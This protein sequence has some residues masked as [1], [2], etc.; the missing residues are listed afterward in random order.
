MKL[1]I[2]KNQYEILIEFFNLHDIKVNI[3]KVIMDEMLVTLG[4]AK[5]V[6]CIVELDITE[7]EIDRIWEICNDYDIAACNSEDSL[8]MEWDPVLHECVYKPTEAERL[9]NRYGLIYT[10]FME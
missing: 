1:E 7:E 5:E 10:Y 3:K 8:S 4:F 2:T 6:P 9:N